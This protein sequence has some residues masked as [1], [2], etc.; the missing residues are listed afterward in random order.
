MLKTTLKVQSKIPHNSQI[1]T[2]FLRLK[3]QGYPVEIVDETRNGDMSMDGLPMILAVSTGGDD[4][5]RFRRRIQ[6]SGYDPA[7][8]GKV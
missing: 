1:I 3:A 6:C 4:C 8:A 5:I 2:G 7:I